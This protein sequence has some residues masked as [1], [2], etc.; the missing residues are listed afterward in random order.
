MPRICDTR[1]VFIYYSG[2]CA[3]FSRAVYLPTSRKITA[4]QAPAGYTSL[5]DK[6]RGLLS[7]N[8]LREV[9]LTRLMPRKF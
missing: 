5:R 2:K 8:V 7:R 3:S 4:D 1:E 9:S 6:H